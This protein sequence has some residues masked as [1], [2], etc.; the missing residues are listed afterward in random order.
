MP[1]NVVPAVI[2]Y[3]DLF[4]TLLCAVTLLCPR[5]RTRF[6]VQALRRLKWSGCLTVGGQIIRDGIPFKTS[7]AITAVI[8]LFQGFRTS[9]GDYPALLNLILSSHFEAIEP[10]KGYLFEGLLLDAIGLAVS[11]LGL[12][13][14]LTQFLWSI[15]G[16]ACLA[17]VLVVSVT[18][19]SISAVDLVL[20]VSFSRLI[21]TIFLWVGKFDPF[22]ITFL[23][24]SANKARL[25]GL[26]GIVLASF[27]HPLV[28]IISTV[29]VV[30]ADSAITLRWAAAAL[31]AAFLGGTMDLLLFR[32]LFAGLQDRAEVVIAQRD[33]MW[34]NGMNWGVVSFVCSIAVPGICIQ[35]FRKLVDRKVDF[36]FVLLGLWLL[37]VAAVSGFLTL[38]HTRVA[39]L[40]TIAPLLVLLRSRQGGQDGL[41]LTALP[42]IFAAL[43]LLRLMTPHID[44]DGAHLF[45][46]VF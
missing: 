9:D 11:W 39:C 33:A 16:M 19:K 17:L 3:E 25:V 10:A 43:L 1:G 36:R 42:R 34:T 46:W 41:S 4:Q 40:L 24:L 2:K 28:T 27:S 37:G 29:G 44:G 30:L 15:S 8:V 45:A 38:D 35:R 5:I 23:V 21:D 13:G 22:L 12:P 20:V 6:S 32:H 18:D 14:P 26:A 31:S 7:C